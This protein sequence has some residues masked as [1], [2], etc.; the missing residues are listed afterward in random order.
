MPAK[1]LFDRAGCY[2]IGKHR[3][4]HVSKLDLGFVNWA[5]LNITGFKEQY[6]AL[7]RGETLPDPKPVI[8]PRSSPDKPKG[9]KYFISKTR[10]MFEP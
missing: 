3:G 10:R 5:S 8:V 1:I 2:L 9:R 6:A 7:A 4:T